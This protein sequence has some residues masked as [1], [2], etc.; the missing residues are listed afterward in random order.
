MSTQEKV[1]SNGRN[2]EKWNQ[3]QGQPATLEVTYATKKAVGPSG[4]YNRRS[5][6]SQRAW[7]KKANNRSLGRSGSNQ[8]Y[9]RLLPVAQRET[10]DLGPPQ[11]TLHE[12]RKGCP[13]DESSSG[14]V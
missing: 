7:N 10:A 5:W 14:L 8:W 13:Q 12:N 2:F 1:S 4:R 9:L 11:R 6:V 3:I